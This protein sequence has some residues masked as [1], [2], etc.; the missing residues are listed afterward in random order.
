MVNFGIS[1]KDGNKYIYVSDSNTGE[2]YVDATFK[3]PSGSFVS[4]L[5]LSKDWVYVTVTTDVES[6]V[7]KAVIKKVESVS[8]GYEL[9]DFD[10]NWVSIC[11]D[12]F[13]DELKIKSRYSFVS[14]HCSR[15]ILLKLFSKLGDWWS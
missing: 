8:N 13:T 5:S 7:I 1:C 4:I 14:F 11:R 9:T 12:V 2:A 15:D 10:G 3:D 6:V